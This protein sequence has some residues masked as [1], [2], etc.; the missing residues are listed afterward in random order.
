MRGHGICV[1]HP[2]ERQAHLRTLTTDAQPG[3]RQRRRYCGYGLVPEKLGVDPE[4]L[5]EDFLLQIAVL[6]DGAA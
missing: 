6:E 1:Q 3:K 2:G 4:T 5:E